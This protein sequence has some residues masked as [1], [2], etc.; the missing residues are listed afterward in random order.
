[1][2]RDFA[3]AFTFCQLLST[4][5]PLRC[6]VLSSIIEASMLGTVTLQTVAFKVPLLFWGSDAGA[7]QDNQRFDVC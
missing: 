4:N 6:S 5:A 1:M 7:K 3:G 2:F